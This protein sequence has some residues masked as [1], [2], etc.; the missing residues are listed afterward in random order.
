MKA[1]L[2]VFI[3]L[4]SECIIL[5]VVK[6]DHSELDVNQVGEASSR[7]NPITAC[8]ESDKPKDS[9]CDTNV[10]GPATAVEDTAEADDAEPV[11]IDPELETNSQP[12]VPQLT[13][14]DT[15][16][17]YST[18]EVP[19]SVGNVQP[20]PPEFIEKKKQT[21]G[22]KK[23]SQKQ[24]TEADPV[25]TEVTEGAW[26]VSCRDDS[27]K[28]SVVLIRRQRQHPT[29]I[30]DVCQ[31]LPACQV[32]PQLSCETVCNT[33]GKNESSQAGE[34]DVIHEQVASIRQESGVGS[35][36]TAAVETACTTAEIAD[37]TSAKNDASV[38][39]TD[40]ISQS[41]VVPSKRRRKMMTNREASRKS[42][43]CSSRQQAADTCAD[44]TPTSTS[45]VEAKTPGSCED[46]QKADD[47]S[48]P[49]L[50]SVRQ[51]QVQ[52]VSAQ[53]SADV[54]DKT[55][56][57]SSV[58]SS[59]I[60][61]S[62]PSMGSS[63]PAPQNYNSNAAASADN[64][65]QPVLST[66][67]VD[68]V[69][70]STFISP[71][72]LDRHDKVDTSEE[73]SASVS[74]SAITSSSL[75]VNVQPTVSTLHVAIKQE[76]KTEQPTYDTWNG[77]G[78]SVAMRVENVAVKCESDSTY[79][80]DVAADLI[81]TSQPSAGTSMLNTCLSETFLKTEERLLHS[82]VIHQHAAD[83]TN[84]EKETGVTETFNAALVNFQLSYESESEEVCK[85]ILVE[86]IADV[87][88][89]ACSMS[90]LKENVENVDSL[91]ADSSVRAPR[92]AAAQNKS[93]D[94][95]G[96]IPLKKRR[97]RRIFSNSQPSDTARSSLQSCDDRHVGVSSRTSSSH[98]KIPSGS[99]RRHSS[100]GNKYV[101]AH[102]SV[103]G[104]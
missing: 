101:G 36:N 76:V 30:P 88:K 11:N 28:N 57:A 10:A 4:M 46:A 31:E 78:S 71:I 32:Q 82:S 49:C 74:A 72:S 89:E 103:V 42:Q 99:S 80:S 73:Q 37:D 23:R 85:T 39:S 61:H 41:A 56:P 75:P 86:V 63:D 97:N 96:E 84:K 9:D 67:N 79:C 47:K 15:S 100:R 8:I 50:I 68:F 7:N 64:I 20:N 51:G 77:L 13:A 95:A 6:D 2:L 43:R 1:T 54:D 22:S 14:S 58:S 60:V 83:E 91:L 98:R 35:V 45:A 21:F 26:Q 92:S 53:T 19:P 38:A 12:L 17:Q 102:T 52:V 40:G 33:E 44:S 25:S 81:A 66:E 24:T 62:G 69:P 27:S 93:D 59:V 29:A 3:K 70:Q 87:V 48:V 55:E 5:C 16:E 94:A 34:S 18:A 65:L 90:A 104:K